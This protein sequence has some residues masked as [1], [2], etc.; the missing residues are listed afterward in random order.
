MTG[1]FT[2]K[3]IISTDALFQEVA[4]E[5]VILDL[6][7]E[8]YFGLNEVGARI[9]QLMQAHGELQQVYDVMLE[10]FD[11]DAQQLQA[12]IQGLVDEL[13]AAGLVTIDG[14]EAA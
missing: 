14:Q 9:W 10:E 3:V 6:K 12:D 13:A 4:G 2:Q 8:S 11:V 7:S 5:I 1:E